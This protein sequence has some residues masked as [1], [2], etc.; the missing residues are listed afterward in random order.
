M[1]LLTT[2][3]ISINQSFY[4]LSTDP[5]CFWVGKGWVG[6]KRCSFALGTGPWRGGSVLILL[7]SH[8]AQHEFA[9]YPAC[10]SS[11]YPVTSEKYNYN[12]CS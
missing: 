1:V 5:V 9:S 10:D 2:G 4:L 7:R 3:Y 8:P 6:W 12:I 11:E